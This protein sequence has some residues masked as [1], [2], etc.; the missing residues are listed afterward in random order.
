MQNSYRKHASMKAN[1][2]YLQESPAAQI[3][4]IFEQNQWLMIFSSSAQRSISSFSWSVH[5]QLV[6]AARQL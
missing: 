2:F 6:L 1:Y 3:S 5:H 4:S